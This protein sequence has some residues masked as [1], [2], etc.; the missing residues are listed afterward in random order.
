MKKLLTIILGI[1]VLVT[2]IYFSVK[3]SPFDKAMAE[4]DKAEQEMDKAISYL[5]SNELEKADLAFDQSIKHIDNA[6]ELLE[7]KG[8]SEVQQVKMEEKLGDI[9]LKGLGYAFG[10]GFAELNSLFDLE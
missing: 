5:E 9:M 1:L 4:L 8:L 7:H 3:D 10:R 2:A 6:A